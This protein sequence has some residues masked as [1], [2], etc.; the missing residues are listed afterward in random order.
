MKNVKTKSSSE[1]HVSRADRASAVFLKLL[2]RTPQR[3]AALSGTPL[4]APPY[5][6]E[7]GGGHTTARA[8]GHSASSPTASRSGAL[9][10]SSVCIA[11]PSRQNARSTGRRP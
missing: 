2:K 4:E 10:H 9:F 1:S 6:Q 11:R 7:T 5:T 8:D 3:I